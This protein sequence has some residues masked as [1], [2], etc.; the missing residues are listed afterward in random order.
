MLYKFVFQTRNSI[1]TTTKYTRCVLRKA[2]YKGSQK[3]LN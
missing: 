2:S 1:R 3:Y